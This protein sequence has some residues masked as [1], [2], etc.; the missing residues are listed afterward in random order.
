MLEGLQ[1]SEGDEDIVLFV[2]NLNAVR[3][4]Q[5]V[6]TNL[7]KEAQVRRMRVARS[8]PRIWADMT[9]AARRAP[10]TNVWW[11]PAHDRHQ[12]WVPL[13]PADPPDELDEEGRY[14]I[15]RPPK[16]QGSYAKSRRGK[17]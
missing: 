15:V 9:T 5:W 2:D 14:Q 10:R 12:D 8:Q 4:V 1:G 6:R 16:P 11:C 17:A 13:A 7:C 3:G